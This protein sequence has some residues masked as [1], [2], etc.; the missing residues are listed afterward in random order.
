VGAIY[1]AH[2]IREIWFANR[3]FSR[4]RELRVVSP[5]IH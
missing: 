5:L 4:F 1:V 3:D 2:G